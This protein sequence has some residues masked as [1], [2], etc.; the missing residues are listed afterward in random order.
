[1]C[2]YESE[3]KIRFET[4]FLQSTAYI[5]AGIYLQLLCYARPIAMRAFRDS[6]CNFFRAQKSLFET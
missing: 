4:T 6:V 3:S 1:M 5:F 2:Y